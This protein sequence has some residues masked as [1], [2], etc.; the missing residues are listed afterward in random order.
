MVLLDLFNTGATLNVKNIYKL[1]REVLLQGQNQNVEA[2]AAAFLPL[3]VKKAVAD[4]GQ[5]KETC[6]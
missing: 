5:V 1:L 4:S 6:Q 2:L 3:I